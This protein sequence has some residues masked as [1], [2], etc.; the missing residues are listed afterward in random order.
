MGAQFKLETVTELKAPALVGC[1]TWSVTQTE[2]HET[3]D[4]WEWVS[5]EGA[6]AEEGEK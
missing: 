5:E 3:G 4:R 1:E 6:C 2:E